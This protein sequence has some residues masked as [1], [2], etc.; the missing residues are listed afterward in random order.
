M[1]AKILKLNL[2]IGLDKIFGLKINRYFKYFR[3][4]K[5]MID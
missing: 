4:I 1:Y 3:Y 5:V 2:K